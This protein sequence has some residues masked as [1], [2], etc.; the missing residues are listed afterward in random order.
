MYFVLS[1]NI[2][3]SKYFAVATMITKSF[4]EMKKGVG[5]VLYCAI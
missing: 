5:S 1:L 2:S 4:H 3:I